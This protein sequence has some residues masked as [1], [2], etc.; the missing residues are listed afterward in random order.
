M[1][2]L[3]DGKAAFKMKFQ[4]PFPSVTSGEHNYKPGTVKPLTTFRL[5]NVKKSGTCFFG[6]SASALSTRRNAETKLNRH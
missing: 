3:L 5:V 2:E 6:Q 4:V 1:T